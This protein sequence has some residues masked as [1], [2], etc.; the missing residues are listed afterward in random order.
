MLVVMRM[1]LQSC[2]FSEFIRL[3]YLKHSW[4]IWF[5]TRWPPGLCALVKI[6]ILN[7]NWIW[8]N[9]SKTAW[10]KFERIAWIHKLKSTNFWCRFSVLYFD[11]PWHL[12]INSSNTSATTQNTL[13]T[14]WCH[15]NILETTKSTWNGTQPI[16]RHWC[17]Q[18][19]ILQYTVQWKR[20]SNETK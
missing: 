6:W 14:V 9:I 1:F 12:P 8:I 4:K 16:M 20:I 15:R 19:Y 5:L 10:F 3:F 2:M 7:L 13:A 17:I 18:N 11:Q